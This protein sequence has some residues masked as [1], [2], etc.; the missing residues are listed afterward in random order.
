MKRRIFGPIAIFSATFVY[1]SDALEGVH[2]NAL[3]DSLVTFADEL[4][5]GGLGPEMVAVPI[6]GHRVKNCIAEK[7]CNESLTDI[8]RSMITSDY[9]ISAY[10]ITF[11][12]YEAFVEATGREYPEDNGWGRGSRPVIFVAWKDALAYVD[13]LTEQTGFKYRLP[14]VI[15]WEHAARAGRHTAYWWGPE[16]E[17]NRA[18]CGDCR[19]KWSQ[20]KTAPVGSF[21][22]NPWGI[23]D[24]HGNVTEFTQ[25]CSMKKRR[26]RLTK[27]FNQKLIAL[28][29]Q[30]K[31]VEKCDWIRLKG[32]PWNATYYSSFRQEHVRNNPYFPERVQSYP[33]R[34]KAA[35]VGIR[36]VREM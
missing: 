9:A 21:P 33:E 30:S 32:S 24:M 4:R 1:A 14:S 20:L 36:V 23:Y 18:N 2:E 22:A 19:S 34:Y 13:W 5:Y 15:E 12:D 26:F 7:V 29:A 11:D 27:R 16:L 17:I 28:S 31:F 10:E 25:D 8:I 6:S 35:G 3:T